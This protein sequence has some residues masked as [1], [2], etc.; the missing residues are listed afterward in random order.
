MATE[1]G[2]SG[3]ARRAASEGFYAVVVGDCVSGS[4][5]LHPVALDYLKTAVDV[6]TC[7]E[8]LAAWRAAGSAEKGD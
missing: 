2:I 6:V 5:E 1:S 3:T 7:D 8:V 4:P